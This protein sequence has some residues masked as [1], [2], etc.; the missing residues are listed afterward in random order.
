MHIF[1][2]E[3]KTSPQSNNIIRPSYFIISTTIWLSKSVYI[4]YLEDTWAIYKIKYFIPFFNLMI[5]SKSLIIL[6]FT[7]LYIH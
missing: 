6:F 3:G 5:F 7:Q 2:D 1:K 4:S